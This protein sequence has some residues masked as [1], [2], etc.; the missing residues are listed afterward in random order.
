MK[1]LA[2]ALALTFLSTCAGLFAQ[3]ASLEVLSKDA[4]A[5]A[6]LPRL[7]MPANYSSQALPAVKDNTDLIFFPGIYSQEVCNCNQAAS[8]WLMYTYE[9]NYLRGLESANP[10]NQYSPMAVFNLMNYDYSSSCPG[11]SYFDTWSIIKANGIPGSTDFPVNSQN[12]Y[13]WMSG[14]DKYY[15][16]MKNRVDQVYAIDVG[17]PEG[18]I[19][20]KH[21]IHDHLAYSDIGGVANFQIGSG[22]M[23]TPRIPVGQGLEAE[24]E[25][26]VTAYG[27]N[28]GHAMSFVGWNDNVKYD[29]NGDGWFTNNVD[30]NSDGKVDMRDW[31]VGAMLVVNSWGSYYNNGKLWVQYRLLAEDLNHGGIWNNAVMVVKPKRTYQPQMTVKTKIRYNQRNRIKIQVGVAA[32]PDAREPEFTMDFPCFAFQGDTLP[33]QGFYG[34]G[35][36]LIELGLDITPLLDRF[37]ESGQAKIFLDVIQKSPNE[38]G[39]GR[40]ESFSVMDYSDGTHEY[41]NTGGIMDIHDNA[42]T[43][44]SVMA[45]AKITRPEILSESLPDAVVGQEYRTQIEADGL[46]GP[47]KFTNPKYQ[48]IQSSVNETVTFTGGTT[49]LPMPDQNYRVMDIPFAFPLYDQTY[50]QVSVLQDGGIVMGSKVVQYPYEIDHRLPFYQNRGVYPFFSKLYYPSAA[51]KVTFQASASEVLVR[52]HAATDQSGNEQLTFAAKLLPDGRIQFFYGDVTYNPGFPW[53]SGVSTGNHTDFTLMDYIHTGLKSNT[54]SGAEKT[55]WPT[56]LT[57]GS[58]GDLKGTPTAPGQWQLP[59]E[60]TD[61]N[62]LRTSKTLTLKT[63]GGAGTG[64]SLNTSSVTLYPNPVTDEVWIQL[65]NTDAGRITLEIMDLTGKTVLRKNFEVRGVE[66]LLRCG[67]VAELPQGIYLYRVSGS[68][69]AKGKMVI[70]SAQPR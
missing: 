62:S 7:T 34:L 38:T 22:D 26:I 56:W 52:W 65:K 9:V 59:L 60:L 10:D 16:G 5:L 13:V 33:M 27:P 58:T 6:S 21:W 3:Q 31:E 49:V 28:V 1:K 2:L 17:S 37:P 67:E 41:A 53:I 19:T 35:A 57:L 70:G 54:A 66:E 15:R 40:I 29:V 47:F 64:T 42:M 43:R 20:L 61:G 23:Q 63:A 44:L 18:L 69:F 36:D 4:A 39:A 51:Y 68:A 11:V 50:T 46:V 30:I 25:Y 8:V 14:Y 32:S 55:I 24:G 12:S 48:Y 45:T